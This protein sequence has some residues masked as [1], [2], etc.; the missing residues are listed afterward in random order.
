MFDAL[1]VIRRRISVRTY[2]GMPVSDAV[3]AELRSLF[4]KRRQGPFGN[5]ARFHLLDPDS[6]GE[7]EDSQRLGTYGI[8]RGARLYIAGAV[9]E[10]RR[11]LEDFGYLMER[12]ILEVTAMD[13][14]TCWLAGTFRRKNFAARMGLLPGEMLPAV[15]PVG[16]PAQKLSLAD[17]LMR[18]GAGS[19]RRKPWDELFFA[20]DDQ[21]P[22][23]ER[24]AGR[25]RQPLEAVRL[26]P[27]ASNRQP[28]RIIIDRAGGCHFYLKED[29]PYN[30]LLG[31][32]RLQNI[33]I[34][35]AMCHFELV[36]R[37]HG[38]TGRWTEENPP[39]A[40]PDLEHI[41]S[42]IP[43]EKAGRRQL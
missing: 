31:K 36:A 20:G 5:T 16:L 23:V 39:A 26:G 33:D 13:L 28:W 24:E 27:S 43:D 25:Y 9:K 17:R 3:K 18:Y 34:G 2:D 11:C 21:T 8:I 41:A 29:M 14:G 22:L 10:G 42:W 37:Q 4:G 12:I 35:I 6:S 15:T 7:G 30:R 40:I 19:R 38:I 1:D 32:I